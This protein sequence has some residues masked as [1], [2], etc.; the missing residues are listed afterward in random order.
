MAGVGTMHRFHE[1]KVIRDGGDVRK[2]VAN[3]RSAFAVLLAGPGRFQEKVFGFVG[4]DAGS[5]EREG[6][7][8]IAGKEWLGIEQIH[9]RWS[10]VHKEKNDPLGGAGKG[11]RF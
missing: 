2:Q 9:R 11:W 1:A 8:R 7:A 6:L 4:S 3:L 5:F 10:A